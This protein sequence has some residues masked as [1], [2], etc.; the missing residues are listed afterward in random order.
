MATTDK[1][2]IY[3]QRYETYRHLDR[4]RWQMLQIAVGAG[5]LILAFARDGREPNW[6]VFAIVGLLLTIFGV[7][8][9]KIGHGIN[10][11][12]QVL[13]KAAAAVGDD[14]IPQVSKWWENVSFW[15][16][17]TLIVLG[18][19]CFLNAPFAPVTNRF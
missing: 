16:A 11:N 19:L 10:M 18:V 3:R 14:D 15:V 5:S 8:M 17:L 9:L 2:E 12:S 4:L 7:V 6:W 1:L 13:S